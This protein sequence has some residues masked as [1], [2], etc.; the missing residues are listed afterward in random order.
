M[1]N[2]VEFN[3]WIILADGFYSIYRSLHHTPL[4]DI[5]F[6]SLL[7]STMEHF[8][9]RLKKFFFRHTENFF[10]VIFTNSLQIYFFLQFGRISRW[11]SAEAEG[12]VHH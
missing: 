7:F 6:E 8:M 5:N 11:Y 4:S 12:S 9:W 3:V 10:L 2:V 1:P